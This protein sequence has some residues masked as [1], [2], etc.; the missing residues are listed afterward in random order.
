MCMY[1]N[2]IT[3]TKISVKNKRLFRTNNLDGCCI[4]RDGDFAPKKNA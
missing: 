2:L 3:R 4:R 1:N